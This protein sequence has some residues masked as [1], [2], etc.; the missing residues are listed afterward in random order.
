M[1]AISL[2]VKSK[3][4]SKVYLFLLKNPSARGEEIIN[5]TNFHPS[6]VREA[7]SKMHSRGLIMR[8]K[9]KND[10]IGKNPFIYS[11]VSP[12]VLLKQYAK[13][14]EEQ[15]NSLLDRTL[16]EKI[17]IHIVDKGGKTK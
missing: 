15:W 3:A 8:I 1:Q 12:S 14:L 7:L 13:Q 17:S 10:L 6:T 16:G 9:L 4:Q 2:V 11:A 5:G